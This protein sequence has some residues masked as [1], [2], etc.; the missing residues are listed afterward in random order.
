MGTTA[1]DNKLLRQIQVVWSLDASAPALE[2]EGR[3][4]TWGE[5]RDA[6]L[7]IDRALSEAGIGVGVP[8]GVLLRNRPGLIAVLLALLISQRCIVS[9]SPFQPT[10]GL[11]EDLHKLKLPAVIADAQDWAGEGT[12]GLAQD[13]G[14]LGLSLARGQLSPPDVVSKFQERSQQHEILADTALEI[15][16]SGTTGTPKRIR[17]SYRTMEDSIVDGTNSDAKAEKPAFALKTTPIVMFAPLMHVSGLFGTLLAIFEGRPLVLLEKFSVNGWAD[18]IAEHK[19]RF[20]SLPPTPMRMVLDANVSKDKLASLIG[21]RAGTAPLPPQTQKEFESRYGIPV[22]VQYGAT[23][24]MGGLAG[25]TLKDHKQ[26][27]ATKLG[28]VG[29]PRGD[30]KLRVVDPDTGRETPT[31]EPGVLEVLPTQRLGASEWTRTTDLASIDQDGFL[32][33]HGRADDTIIRGGFKIQLNHV[34]EVL[35][36]HPAVLEAAVIGLADERL[37]QVPVAAIEIRPDAAVPSEAELK[38]YAQQHLTSYQVP[39][40]FKLVPALP[41]TISMKVSRPGV[42]AL[43]EPV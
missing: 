13:L 5:L 22:L 2:F 21:V 1:A 17:I 12:T 40:R 33:I 25:W 24:W 4:F 31:G 14:S 37:G 16:T 26:Y 15:L 10:E 6:A 3:W 19:I 29:R 30:V 28:S 23:E 42:R 34:A 11:H 27:I 9:L 32:Y 20:S 35:M 36:D 7:A 41:R 39:V 38:A 43:F 18:A 8:V